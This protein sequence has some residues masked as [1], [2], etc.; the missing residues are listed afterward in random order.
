MLR[1]SICVALFLSGCAI[2]TPPPIVR[3]K[4]VNKATSIE[5]EKRAIVA[6]SIYRYEIN[7]NRNCSCPY[8]KGGSCKGR[9][10]YERPGGARPR[11]YVTDVS[12]EDLIRWRALLKGGVRE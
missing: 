1:V 7:L 12:E 8:S 5:D 9:S 11:C 2:D 10:A 3:T 4:I 6:A